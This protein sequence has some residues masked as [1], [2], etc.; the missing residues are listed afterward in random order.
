MMMTVNPDK[1]K[2]IRIKKKKQKNTDDVTENDDRYDNN[3]DDLEVVTVT[4][5]KVMIM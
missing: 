1:T 4:M 2:K 3:S 5:T